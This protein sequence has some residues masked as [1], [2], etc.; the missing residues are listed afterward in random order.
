[1][2]DI[3]DQRTRSRMMAGIKSANTKPE[4]ELRKAVHALG[5]R[6]RLH[7]DEIVGRPDL[8]MPK[9]KAVVFVHGCFWHRHKGCA[10]ATTPKTRVDFWTTKFAQNVRRDAR[11]N[12]LLRRDGWK[13]VTV[14]ECQTLTT[15]RLKARLLRVLG[16]I[17]D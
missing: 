4:R 8:V 17:E 9:H 11:N 15:D 2:A 16:V 13:V 1:M 12:K 5:F 3:V 14:W 7:A 10:K 6:Y